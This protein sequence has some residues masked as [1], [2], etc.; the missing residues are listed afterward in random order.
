MSFRS[1]EYIERFEH[2]PIEL[3]TPLET[4]LRSNQ[5][6]RR[7]GLEFQV[8][9]L[10]RPIDWYDSY[11]KIG[12]VVNQLA[13]GQNYVDSPNAIAPC[14]GVQSFVKNLSVKA[15]GT[16]VY[17]GTMLAVGLFVKNLLTFSKAYAE[18]TAKNTFWYL[19]EKDE[20]NIA[21]NQAFKFRN[22]AILNGQ[23]VHAQ[24][25]LNYF[26]FFDSLNDKIIP[27][28]QMNLIFDLESDNNII[29]RAGTIRKRPAADGLPEQPEVAAVPSGRVIITNFTLW[30]KRINFNGVGLEKTSK[31]FFKTYTWSYQTEIVQRSHL[32]TQRR[33]EWQIMSAFKPRHVFIWF[34]NANRD[35]NQEK[36]SLMFDLLN[37][38]SCQLFVGNGDIYPECRYEMANKDRIFRNAI[39]Y[40]AG[41]N[42]FDTSTQLTPWLWEHRYLLY[43]FDLSYHRSM[44]DSS[45]QTL[46]FV[47]DLSNNP[48]EG[49]TYYINALILQEQKAMYDAKTNKLT[50]D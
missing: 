38:V 39:E 9:D 26:S 22:I 6:Q 17:N 20:P 2:T 31:E 27:P 18:S 40:V 21:S 45:A 37:L 16:Q 42:Y 29:W 5:L 12:F 43:Y 33:G 49:T 36:N 10:S 24:L 23:T 15:N 32:Q 14:C 1:P 46:K 3:T 25:P 44:L 48:S 34:S 13:N 8:N 35:D 11:V 28:M 41:S 7:T 50:V 4:T 47:W 19:D 30:I